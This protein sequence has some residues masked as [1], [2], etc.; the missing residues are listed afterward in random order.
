MLSPFPIGTTL[1]FASIKPSFKDM[2]E[3]YLKIT[4][5]QGEAILLNWPTAKEENVPK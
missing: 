1:D 2:M 3:V 4:D 5:L